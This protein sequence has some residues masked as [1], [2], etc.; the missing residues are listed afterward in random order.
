MI[1][2]LIF[3]FFN[4]LIFPKENVVKSMVGSTLSKLMREKDG[5]DEHFV[6]NSQLLEFLE[7][8][9]DKYKLAAFT[10]SRSLVQLP[11][12]QQRLKPIF[13]HIFLAGNLELSK[14]DHNSYLELAK[15]LDAQS[16]QILFVDDQ[17]HNIEAAQQAGLNTI[18]FQDTSQF[19]RDLSK[20]LDLPDKIPS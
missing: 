11:K 13:D 1:T 3:D 8:L 12:V 6:L 5:V 14:S 20:F 18:H 4:V 19:L 17:L 7:Q 10:N 2:H 15:M 9:P 16:S